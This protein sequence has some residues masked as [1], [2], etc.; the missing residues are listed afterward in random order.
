MLPLL[1]LLLVLDAGSALP[2]GY[3]RSVC[4]SIC[5][6]FLL[7]INSLRFTLQ[8]GGGGQGGG[9]KGY[10]QVRGNC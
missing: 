4:S 7:N 2:Q 9:D 8:Q 5:L 3:G 10:P 1:L 6:R